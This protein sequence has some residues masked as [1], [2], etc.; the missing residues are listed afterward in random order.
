MTT[1]TRSTERK[2]ATPRKPRRRHGLGIDGIRAVLDRQDGGCAICGTPEGVG[3]GT[4]LAVDHDHAHCP[5]KTGCPECVRGLLCVHCNNM[6]RA[7]KDDPAILRT[8]IAYL[9]GTTRPR[10]AR[11]A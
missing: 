5:G 9:A 6:L 11:T 4:R 1:M 2:D 8:A 3:P 10:R 7:A